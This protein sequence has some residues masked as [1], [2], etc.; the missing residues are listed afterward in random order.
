MSTKIRIIE[1]EKNNKTMSARI[2]SSEEVD[3]D[4]EPAHSSLLI[5]KPLIPFNSSHRPEI[6]LSRTMVV[7]WSE[8]YAVNLPAKGR[9]TPVQL[10]DVEILHLGA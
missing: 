4:G 1:S 9:T 6:S 7:K 3:Y 2:K 5:N 10:L 8:P